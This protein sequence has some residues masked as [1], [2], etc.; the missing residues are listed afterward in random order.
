MN[1]IVLRGDIPRR[2]DEVDQ[3]Q[4]VLAVPPPL[5]PDALRVSIRVR[6]NQYRTLHSSCASITDGRAHG[7]SFYPT[8][9]V[10]YSR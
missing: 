2:N 9:A 6:L 10:D 1:T 5:G 3:D 8:F 7:G 4:E